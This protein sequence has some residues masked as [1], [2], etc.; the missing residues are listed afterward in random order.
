M[1]AANNL[2]FIELQTKYATSMFLK[3]FT[4]EIRQM[5]LRTGRMTHHKGIQTESIG[6]CSWIQGG[7]QIPNLDL[8][9]VGTANDSFRIETNAANQFLMA[10]QDT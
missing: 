1:R 4:I 9:I 8:A 5:L 7:D 3:G 10:L 6:G 2:E